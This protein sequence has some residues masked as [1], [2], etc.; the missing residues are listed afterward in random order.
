MRSDLVFRAMANV[1][2]RYQLSQLAAKAAR[3]LHKPGTRLQETANDVLER[4]SRSNPIGAEQ[5]L[6]ERHVVQLRPKGTRPVRL[7]K[8]EVV[9]L[10]PVKENSDPLWETESVL[11]A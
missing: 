4:F 2:N 9:S 10:P 5:P 11:S 1:P 3:K 8:S 7:H 6:R